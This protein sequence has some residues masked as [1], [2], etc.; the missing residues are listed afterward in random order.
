MPEETPT[1]TPKPTASF[2]DPTIKETAS[3]LEKGIPPPLKQGYQ[4][5]LAAGMKFLFDRKTNRFLQDRAAMLDPE[6]TDP[7]FLA[8]EAMKMFNIIWRESKGKVQMESAFYALMMLSLHALDFFDRIGVIRIDPDFLAAFFQRLSGLFL[9]FF[10]IDQPQIVAA[11]QRGQKEIQGMAGAGAQ[12][13]APPTAGPKPGM[14]EQ[15]PEGGP[16]HG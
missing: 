8:E 7:A 4:R 6:A 9:K 2:Q 11:I 1:T 16:P 5:T 12:T 3:R 10:K 15:A 13:A 14:M